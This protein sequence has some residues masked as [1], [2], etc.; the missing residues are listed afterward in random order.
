V[1]HEA[2]RTLSAAD[3]AAILRPGGLVAD[4]K[5]MWPAPAADAAST[6]HYWSI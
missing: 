4:I 6:H 3:L 2:F 5:R 1:R